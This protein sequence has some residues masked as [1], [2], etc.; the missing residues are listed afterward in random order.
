MLDLATSRGRII[1]AAL[2]LAANKPWCDVS[3]NEIAQSAGVTLVDLSKEFYGK[4]SIM[5]AFTKLVDEQVLAR[6]VAGLRG[7]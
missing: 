2:R 3:L 6:D 7:N 5:A 1:D 4:L